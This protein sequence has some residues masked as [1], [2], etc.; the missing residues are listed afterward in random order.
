MRE[1]KRSSD[2]E[3]EAAL[4]KHSTQIACNDPL[5]FSNADVVTQHFGDHWG[6]S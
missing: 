2:D 4:Q 5:D 6:V 3:D 1:T